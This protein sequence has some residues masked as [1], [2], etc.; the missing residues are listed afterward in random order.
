MVAEPTDEPEEAR[1]PSRTPKQEVVEMSRRLSWSS[2]PPMRCFAVCL[3]VL[4]IAALT[5]SAIAGDPGGPG[6][7]SRSQTVRL[8]IAPPDRERA[9]SE[10]L[11]AVRGARAETLWIFDANFEDLLGDNAGWTSTDESGTRPVVNYW[12]KDT[13]RMGGFPFLGDSTWWCGTYDPCWRQPRGYGNDWICSLSRDFPEVAAFTEPGDELVLEYDQRFAMENDYDYGYTDISINGGET[14]ITIRMVDNPGFAGTPGVPQDWDATTF[15]H[16]ALNI[17]AYAGQFIC[18]RFRFESDCAYSSQDQYD[19]SYHPCLDGAWQLDNIELW[20]DSGSGPYTVFLDDCESPGPNGWTHPDIP[21]EGQTGVV[22]R[23]GLYGTDLWTNRSATCNEQSGWMYAAVDPA[24]SRM[25][26]DQLSWLVSPPIDIDGA[27]VLVGQWEGWLDL[28]RESDDL[29]DLWLAS[30]DD[31]ECILYSDGFIDDYPGSTYGGPTWGTWTD[32][33]SCYAGNPWLA[34]RWMTIGGVPEPGAEHMGG[35]FL[36]RQRVG[37]VQWPDVWTSWELS[38]WRRFNDWFVDQLADALL[39]SAEVRVTD[40]DGVA[41]VSLVCSDDAGETWQSYSCIN[42]W[43]QSDSWMVPVPADLMVGGAEILHYFEA[44][45][46]LGNVSTYPAGAP[47]ERFEFSILPV[48]SSVSDPG[49]LLVD[50]HGARAL[51]E[52]RR[53]GNYSEEYY[54]EALTIL[55]YT[56]DVFDVLVP[57]SVSQSRGPDTCGMKYY[58]TQIWFSN[59][60]SGHLTILEDDASLIYWLSQAGEGRERNLLMTGNESGGDLAGNDT[61]S[62]GSAWLALDYVADTVGDVSVDSVPTLVEHAG[63]SH[64]MTFDDARCLLRGGCP[65]LCDFDVIEPRLGVTG[66]ETAVEYL[67]SDMSTRPAGVAYTDTALGYQAVTLGF[68]ME[69]MS[70][71]RLPGGYFASGAS[72]RVDLMSNI[73]AYFAKAPDDS[74]TGTEESEVFAFRL[75]HPRPNPFNP[76]TTLAFTLP[77]PGAVRL[78]VFDAAGRLVATL[79]ERGLDAGEHRVTWDGSTDSGVRA[80]SGVYFIRLSACGREAGR[81]MVL[82]K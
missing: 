15:G 28:P 56:Y 39:D 5:G 67:L 18:I 23:R 66:A 4:A 54:R 33:W 64:F 53:Y 22:F 49:I 74:A 44:V 65:E 25:V 62:F 9:G 41:S 24:S 16:Q 58:D 36:G 42:Y 37:V 63:G 46:S 52:D 79:V 40:S 73:M 31:E 2:T 75:E 13:I 38:P 69:F 78:M 57:G 14:W 7:E 27:L 10:D 11:G 71:E 1:A 50:K 12:H 55:G 19:N 81:K 70:G 34:V 68:G 43:W 20:A 3:V 48:N 60:R 61:L 21:G 45:D 35:F 6:A 17:S 51:G 26:D 30:G 8:P 29:F 77:E 76:T 72:D 47:E 32:D 82:L 59:T 80:A